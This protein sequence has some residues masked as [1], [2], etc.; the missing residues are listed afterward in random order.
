MPLADAKEGTIV[1]EG[2]YDL[3]ILKYSEEV[4][5]K[6]KEAGRKEPNMCHLVI[7]VDSDDHTNVPPIHHYLIYPTGGEWDHLQVLSTKRV[8]TVFN[9]PFEGNGFNTDDLEGARGKCAVGVETRDDGSEV[10]VINAPRLPAEEE[11]EDVPVSKPSGRRGAAA[12][13]KRPTG[14]RSR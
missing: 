4:S 6:A 5:K 10:N 3:V 9:I 7:G 8:L 12:E 13:S 1:P 11:E 2:E 14:R